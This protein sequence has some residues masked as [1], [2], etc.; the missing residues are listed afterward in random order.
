MVMLCLERSLSNLFRLTAFFLA[1]ML[2]GDAPPPILKVM[3]LISNDGTPVLLD[4][5][6][7]KSLA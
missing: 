2:S 6:L 1:L 5:L 4:I 7:E 3:T